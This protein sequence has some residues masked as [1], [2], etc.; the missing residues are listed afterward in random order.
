MIYDFK[1]LVS[2]N[3]NNVILDSIVSQSPKT[4]CQEKIH[5]LQIQSKQKT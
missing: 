4:D 3:V 2:S 5:C 1:A